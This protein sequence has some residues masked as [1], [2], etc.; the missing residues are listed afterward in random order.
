[1]ANK[2]FVRGSWDWALFLSV[3]I[4]LGIGIIMVYSSSYSWM[5]YQGGNP[6]ELFYKEI[7]FSV[8]GMIL[9]VAASK[10]NHRKLRKWVYPL[11]ILNFILYALLYTPLGVKNYNSVR[12][13]RLPGNFTF[14]PS[15]MAKYVAILTVAYLLTL[16]KEEKNKVGIVLLIAFQIAYIG[17]TLK[18]PDLSTSVVIAASIGAVLFFGG[19]QWQYI[20]GLVASGA[21]GAV[22]I[23]MRSENKMNRVR[24]FLDPLSD[25]QNT[26][27][28]II[29]SL[30]AISSGML[31]GA[32]IG[33]GTQKRIYLPFA[34]NDYIFSIFAEEYGFV[35]CVL[36]IIVLS[37]LIFRGFKVV[38][39][40]PDKFGSLI[41]AGII[42]QIT[43]QSFMNM[44]VS[45]N[46]VP[47]TGIP[48]PIVSY[49]GTSLLLTL[50]AIGILLGISRWEQKTQKAFDNVE[51]KNYHSLERR[52]RA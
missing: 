17:L 19:L 31:T 30:Y 42:S 3:L 4:L 20:I 24:V 8:A 21:A 44:Y 33:K 28:Q 48:F 9:L 38:A 49:G 16:K 25:P 40:A 18:Q 11:N 37:V 51:N 10:L 52:K 46:L 39:N 27:F 2:Y 34:Y 43:I 32:G 26:G 29:Q 22:F 35:G 41:A 5:E 50:G 47:S 14:M 15:E 13:V 7:F 12:W 1:M 45:A 23:I 6:N 36:F